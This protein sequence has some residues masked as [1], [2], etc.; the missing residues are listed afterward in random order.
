LIVDAHEDLAY[1][2]LTFGRDYNRAAAQT[3]MLERGTDPPRLTGESLLGWPD[4]QRGRIAVVFAT[5]FA[6]P[7]RNWQGEWDTQCYRDP[8]EAHRLYRTQLELYYRLADDHPER[9]RL[10]RSQA[11]LDE[12]LG[13]WEQDHPEGHPVGLVLLMEGAEG[14]QEPGELEFWWEGGVRLIG[15]AW[16]GTR[17][18]GGTKEPGPLTPEGYALLDGMAGGGFGLDVS[19]MDE[20]A[21]L[22]ALDYYP[23][24]I[25]AS[26]ANALALLD[27]LE[28]NR[29]LSDRVLRG[30]LEREAVIGIVPA[31]GFLKRDWKLRGGREA[32]TLDHVVAQ[33][34]YICQLAGDA[35]HVGLGSDFDGGFGLQSVPA[36]IY[37]IADLQKL[38]LPLFERGYGEDDVA[39]I[40]G[41]NWLSILGAILPGGI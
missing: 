24:T 34:D 41:Q 13:H 30:L 4:F 7:R 22:Q 3:R 29:H 1:N 25:I 12:V 37:S 27:G 19:H 36:E 16:M 31:N 21:V 18:C 15:P 10:V 40:L 35:R 2:M 23:G 20:Q 6:A 17:Y 39:A 5:L 28:S 8:Q 26:H 33:I 11:D 38:A 9:F 32:V 14:V